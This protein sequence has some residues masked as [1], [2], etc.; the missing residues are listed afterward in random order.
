MSAVVLLG[1]QWGDEG[2]G[3]ITDFLAEKADC[4]VRY[5]GGS[6]AGHTVEVASEKF[7]LHLIPSGI[8]YPKTTCV[9][10]NGVVID[11]GAIIEEMN[12]LKDRGIDVSN[13][14]I[15]S[16]AP[17][18]MP[19]HKR[20]DAIED[21]AKKIG[22]TKKGIGPAYEDKMARTGFRI[23]DLLY[24]PEFDSKFREQVEKKNILLERIY[25]VEGFEA[26]A[27]LEELHQQVSCLEPY[28][29]DTSCL[30][31]NAIQEGKKV[32][33]EGAQGTLLDIDHGTYPFVT[34]SYPTAGGAC[35]GAGVG[36]TCIS[37]VLGIAKAYTTRVGEGPFPTELTDELGEV[38]RNRGA[39]FGVTTG[40]PRRCGWLDAVI[41]RYA[42]RING[43][44][45]FAITKLD[46][47]D[48]LET[49][50]IC[51]AYN[52]KGKRLTEFPENINVLEECSPEYIELPGWQTDISGISRYED[53]PENTRRYLDKIKELT[54]IR[55]SL[56]AV[57]PRRDQTI[58]QDQLF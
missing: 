5:Q 32:L 30:V 15:S 13:L 6:N 10:G 38:L 34:S 40:R 31:Y 47:L 11:M 44:T 21:E 17:I 24:D 16:R 41:L 9:V 54:G 28:V 36:P 51:V 46:V 50:K 58:V 49:V 45:D 29:T 55:Q 56:I 57:G 1:S 27:L 23:C 7:M 18:V 52:Y 43:L 33:F 19:Y 22:T 25:G 12:G 53:L 2:K 20:M 8:L 39:E 37:R 4:V 35:V 26:G 42:V 3:K 48:T 14:R